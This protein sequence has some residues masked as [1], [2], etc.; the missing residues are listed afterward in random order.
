MSRRFKSVPYLSVSENLK[1]TYKG[2]RHG[3]KDTKATD[4]VDTEGSKWRRKLGH[5]RVPRFNDFP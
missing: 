4:G 1:V 5:C 2:D 3:N